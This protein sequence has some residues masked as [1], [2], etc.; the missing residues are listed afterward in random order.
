MEISESS[1]RTV[2]IICLGGL[3]LGVVLAVAGGAWQ[4]LVKPEHVWSQE[5][6]N[7][8]QAARTEWHN[9]IYDDPQSP[10]A[11]ESTARQRQREA[12]QRRFE[13]MQTELDSAI[14]SR[15]YRGARLVYAGLAAMAAFGVGYLATRRG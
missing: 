10:V 14:A 15:R 11:A 13:E 8:M 5:E 7:Q 4:A 2:E 12:A 6:A 3:V 1:R 9:L